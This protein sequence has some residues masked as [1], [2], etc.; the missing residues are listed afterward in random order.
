M[1]MWKPIAPGVGCIRLSRG[2]IP[3]DGESLEQGPGA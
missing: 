2:D 1:E 3:G